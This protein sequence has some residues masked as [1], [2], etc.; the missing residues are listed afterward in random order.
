MVSLDSITDLYPTHQLADE[1]LFKKAEIY[2]KHNDFEK[3][4]EN[5]KK[6]VD[7]YPREITAD[8][9]CYRLAQLYETKM[10]NTQKAAEY[11]KKILIDY[12]SSIFIND[13]RK[14]YRAIEK[15]TGKQ[16]NKESSFL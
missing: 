6:I 2:Q 15:Q 10:N 12:K 4:A 8:D 13:S 14:H 11:Y 7:N 9:A 3:A 1:I 16:E 5:L